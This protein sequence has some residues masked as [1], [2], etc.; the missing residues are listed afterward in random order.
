M[1]KTFVTL[2]AALA[3]LVT[4][5]LAQR[6][7]TNQSWEGAT[8]EMQRRGPTSTLRGPLSD[9]RIVVTPGYHK[10]YVKRYH[11]HHRYYGM[12]R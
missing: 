7:T 9:G 11:R 12:A 8:H 10:R 5:A 2:V 6:A 1:P 4:P 3:A